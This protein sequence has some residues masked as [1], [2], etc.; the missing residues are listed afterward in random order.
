MSR[1][2]PPR[3]IVGAP[4]QRGRVRLT[5]RVDLEIGSIGFGSLISFVAFSVPV[6]FEFY[7]LSLIEHGNW[8]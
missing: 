3:I 4:V 7:T 5:K 8:H 6:R 2:L 1:K